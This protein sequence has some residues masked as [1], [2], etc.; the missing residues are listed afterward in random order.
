M[1][2]RC[3]ELL[4]ERVVTAPEQGTLVTFRVDGDPAELVV[5]LY[6]AGVVVR[7]VPP[8]QWIRVSC[9]WWTSEEDLRRLVGALP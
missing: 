2:N 8:T 1:A 6:E 9:G 7:S 4:G 3:R 5:S